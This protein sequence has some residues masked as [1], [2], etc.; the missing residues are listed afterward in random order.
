[1]ILIKSV[2]NYLE[3]ILCAP[4]EEREIRFYM[5]LLVSL[6]SNPAIKRNPFDNEQMTFEDTAEA[7]IDQANEIILELNHRGKQNE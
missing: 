1:M 5:D 6:A 4:P 2:T 3:S 7:I